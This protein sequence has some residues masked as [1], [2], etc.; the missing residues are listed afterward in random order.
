MVDIITKYRCQVCGL[1]GDDKEQIIEHEKSPVIA[2]YD[3]SIGLLFK[4]SHFP[5]PKNSSI[6]QVLNSDDRHINNAYAVIHHLLGI[7]QKHE[8]I[9]NLFYFSIN[10]EVNK[11]DFNT[12][13]LKLEYHSTDNPAASRINV[14]RGLELLSEEEFDD[15]Q[16]LMKIA[17]RGSK[18]A[19]RGESFK[20][21]ASLEFKIVP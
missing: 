11:E 6:A 21:L 5:Y 19:R 20:A 9:Y 17:K 13:Q 8:R 1:I 4:F 2:P 14:E 16:K 10:G 18:R 3:K 15:L 7:N 12:G